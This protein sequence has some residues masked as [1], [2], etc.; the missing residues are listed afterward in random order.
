MA[1]NF[2]RLI[3]L[4]LGVSWLL[5]CA[6]PG[7][8]ANPNQAV[9][10][11]IPPPTPYGMS[12]LRGD[13]YQFDDTDLDL[14]VAGLSLAEHVVKLQ[15]AQSEGG[16]YSGDM[17]EPLSDMGRAY[18][19][20]NRHPDA[21]DQFRRAVHLLRVNEG[22]YTPSQ[23]PVLEALI[24]SQRALGR[25]EA[26]DAS[27]EYL[28]RVQEGALDPSDEKLLKAAV[29]YSEWKREAYLTRVGSE[30][31]LRLLDMHRTHTRAVE[32]IL[33]VDPD[34]AAQIPYLY[35]QV[36]AGY[37]IS[38]YDGERYPSFQTTG[39]A[40]IGDPSVSTTKLEWLA[41]QQL[42]DYNFRNGRR[43]LDQIVALEG[44]RDPV[45]SQAL[46][47][48]YSALGDWHM[49]WDRKTRAIQAYEKAAA[50]LGERSQLGLPVT[51]LFERPL[52][53]PIEPVFYTANTTGTATVERKKARAVVRF[54][55]SRLGEA[56]RIE[57]VELDPPESVEARL[58]LIGMLK[59]FRFRPII[60]SGQATVA[61]SIEREYNFHY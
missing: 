21:V 56:K 10:P 8:A 53:L 29:D 6:A 31:Y 59:R 40:M 17:I 20:F 14:P 3:L 4:S 19:L 24:R 48:A 34:D 52:E 7:W 15:D 51:E 1:L 49:W 28:Y 44:S 2:M 23:I 12:I 36:R 16:P 30:T 37:L 13:E 54:N 50:V 58:A 46:A 18:Q 39:S 45:N 60:R 25:M 47:Q 11:R 43:A 41:F 55:V 27:R 61:S 57:I 26:V 22:L 35:Q 9:D 32:K 5:F 42:R 33:T 38:Q